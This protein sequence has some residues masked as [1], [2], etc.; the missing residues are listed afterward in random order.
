M[1]TRFAGIGSQSE[2]RS[3]AEK[4]PGAIHYVCVY[5]RVCVYLEIDEYR[6]EILVHAAGSAVW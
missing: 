6:K 5:E 1:I 2:N 3:C 4:S